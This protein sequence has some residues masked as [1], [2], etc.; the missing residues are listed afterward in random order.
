MSD[1]ICKHGKHVENPCVE[2]DE[3]KAE[4]QSEL[5]ATPC[6]AETSDWPKP[7]APDFAEK[8]KAKCESEARRMNITMDE[9]MDRLACKL[10]FDNGIPPNIR[11]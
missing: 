4:R 1:Q 11:S 10:F 5:S 6:S 9:Y 3:E 8:L 7:D 2:C